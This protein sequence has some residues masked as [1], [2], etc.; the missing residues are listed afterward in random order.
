[1]AK[2]YITKDENNII[3]NAFSDA[4]ETSQEN[5]ICINEKGGRHYNLEITDGRGKYKYKYVNKKITERTE[6]EKWT[7]GEK[8]AI[9]K[10]KLIKEEI[11]LFQRTQAIQ[12]LKD[13][14]KLDTN[15][16]LIK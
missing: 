16:N 1:M 12:N 2:H 4:F 14:N 13:Q 8:D 11:R 5:D 10:E 3:T 9:E 15:E 7:Q 6:A